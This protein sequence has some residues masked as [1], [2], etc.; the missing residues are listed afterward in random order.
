MNAL[1][2][3]LLDSIGATLSSAGN[4][5]FIGCLIVVIAIVAICKLSELAD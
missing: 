5:F 1:D 4:S 2:F 3:R